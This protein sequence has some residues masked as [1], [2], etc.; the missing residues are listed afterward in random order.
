MYIS[1][2][3]LTLNSAQTLKLTEVSGHEF[4]YLY[5]YSNFMSLFSTH[6]SFR[7]LPS[8]VAKFSLS[9]VS[10]ICIHVYIFI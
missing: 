8:S 10:Q 1:D 9:E 7:S 3:D 6:V 2:W 5:S 4:S